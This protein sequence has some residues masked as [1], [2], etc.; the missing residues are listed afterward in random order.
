MSAEQIDKVLRSLGVEAE[1]DTEFGQY[2]AIVAEHDGE[3]LLGCTV[4]VDDGHCLIAT[5]MIAQA[6]PD[7]R[8]PAVVEFIT[9]INFSQTYGGFDVDI[10]ESFVQFR[11]GLDFTN[12]TLTDTLVRNTILGAING[13]RGY[14]NSLVSVIEGDDALTAWQTATGNS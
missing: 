12:E 11:T 1:L 13:M 2:R 5:A 14:L 4:R 7:D 3:P 6:V 10:D 8:L 9:R